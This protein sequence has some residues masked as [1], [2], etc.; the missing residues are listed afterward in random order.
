MTPRP[1]HCAV[2]L[3]LALAGPAA[4]APP[5]AEPPA[6]AQPTIGATPVPIT[7]P[8][9]RNAFPQ[10]I[11][12]RMRAALLAQTGPAPTAEPAAAAPDSHGG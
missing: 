8:E 9:L 12:A 7:L 4:A 3:L 6:A 5:A 10:D 2:A 11:L 1:R